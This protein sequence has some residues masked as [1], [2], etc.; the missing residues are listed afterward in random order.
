M[1]KLITLLV[2]GIPAIISGVIAFLARKLGTVTASMAAFGI[3]TVAFIASIN[4][5][6]NTVLAAMQLTPWAATAV[7][8]FIPSNFG[9]VLGAVVAAKISK[10]AYDLAISK[11]KV[12]SAAN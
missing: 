1:I 3:L 12:I 6:L 11:V 10:A 7:G 9:V 8:M 4:T 5:A 2:T